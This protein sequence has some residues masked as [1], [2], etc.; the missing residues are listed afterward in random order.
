MASPTYST[1]HPW[2]PSG[3]AASPHSSKDGGEAAAQL[4]AQ[5]SI[6]GAA[7]AGSGQVHGGASSIRGCGSDDVAVSVL[8]CDVSRATTRCG[9]PATRCATPLPSVVELGGTGCPPARQVRRPTID[10]KSRFCTS[11]A[12]FRLNQTPVDLGLLA[13]H[14]PGGNCIY[15]ISTS[16]KA[17][18]DKM[19]MAKLLM[20]VKRR[21]GPGAEKRHVHLQIFKNGYV[22]IMGA[23]SYDEVLRI[24]ARTIDKIKRSKGEDRSGDARFAVPSPNELQV[25]ECEGADANGIRWT[26]LRFDFDLGFSL[27]LDTVASVLGKHFH[28]TYEPELSYF[29]GITIKAAPTASVVIYA[30]GKGFVTV[31]KDLGN[32]TRCMDAGQDEGI[33][34][35]HDT[36]TGASSVTKG[37]LDLELTEAYDKVCEVLWRNLK[38]VANLARRVAPR[39]K[40][41]QH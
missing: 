13:T 20:P 9:T 39:K 27:K 8:S 37:M 6:V 23:K 3:C 24:A 25:G 34:E 21:S 11:T 36:S 14:I 31:S 28:L 29:K 12:S 30:S 17:K 2:D 40:P 41:A 33:S 5:L 16:G 10:V 35:C 18:A 4:H 22:C 19:D 26:C 32:E 38:L 7:R 1:A 15:N